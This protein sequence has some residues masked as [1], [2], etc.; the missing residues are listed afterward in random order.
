MELSSTFESAGQGLTGD[1]AAS[2][3]LQ[4]DIAQ[5]CLPAATRDPNRKLAYVNS[6]CLAFIVV[7]MLGVNP[8]KYV[9]KPLPELLEIVPVI[10]TPPPEEQPP[11]DPDQI[12]PEDATPPDPASPAPIVAT[13]VAAPSAAVS[14]PVPVEGPVSLVPVKYAGPPPAILPKPRPVTVTAPTPV[15]LVTSKVQGG[16]FPPPQFVSG[17]LRNGESATVEV[18]I[19]VA[20]DGSMTKV[21]VDK[22]SGYLELDRRTVQHIRNRWRFPPGEARLYVYPVEYTATR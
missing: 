21:E 14:F 19:E 7:G 18:R 1:G 8:P 6:I 22:T 3:R 12:P 17:V 11:P 4:S 20:P 13:L 9:Q 15:R 5:F 10:F 2:Y 16:S